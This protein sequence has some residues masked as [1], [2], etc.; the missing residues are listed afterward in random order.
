MLINITR[1]RPESILYN[2][3]S[4]LINKAM[5]LGEVLES[6]SMELVSYLLI[7]NQLRDKLILKTTSDFA[8][9]IKANAGFSYTGW[10]PTV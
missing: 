9:N 1:K 2:T 3:L 8:S 10:G 5:N 4:Y 6:V 7:S